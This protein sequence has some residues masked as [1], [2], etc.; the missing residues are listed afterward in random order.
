[1]RNTPITFGALEIARELISIPIH[2]HQL[3]QECYLGM[4]LLPF[5]IVLEIYYFIVMAMTIILKN[6]IT[7]D[8]EL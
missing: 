7:E 4:D 2:P 5:A 1:M 6:F 3:L 8:Q